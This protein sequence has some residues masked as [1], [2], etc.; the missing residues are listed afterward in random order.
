MTDNGDGTLKAEADKKDATVTFTNIYEAKGTT[1]LEIKKA[2][3]EGSKW[4]DGKTAEFVLSAVT[5][6]APMPE[7]GKEKVALKAEGTGA[8]GAITWSNANV[9]KEYTY[10]IE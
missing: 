6:G 2:L 3:A 4:P 8:F 9:G 10:K 5:K 1:V 7:S